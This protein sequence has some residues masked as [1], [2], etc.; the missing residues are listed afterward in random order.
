MKLASLKEWA[1][2]ELLKGAPQVGDIAHV[3]W[4]IVQARTRA[5]VRYALDLLRDLQAEAPARSTH[6]L[7]ER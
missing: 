5:D 4:Y 1:W 6:A 3:G 2:R 7:D